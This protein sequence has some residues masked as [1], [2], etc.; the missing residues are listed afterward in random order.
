MSVPRYRSSRFEVGDD[1][2]MGP[3]AN[4]ADIMLVFAVGLMIALASAGDGVKPMRTGG[5][6]VEAGREL[7][8]VP[9]GAGEAGSGYEA[10]GQVYRDR[11]TGRMVLI[12]GED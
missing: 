1:D 11:D 12:G 4:L 2:P 6:D 7:P 5:A 10:V 8:E 9:A 3:L